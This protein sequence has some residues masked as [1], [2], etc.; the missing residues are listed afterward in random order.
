MLDRRLSCDIERK[1]GFS[2]RGACG[3]NYEVGFLEAGEHGVERGEARGDSAQ[4]AIMLVPDLPDNTEVTLH[5]AETD[6]DPK[7]ALLDDEETLLALYAACAE[8]DRELAS[9]GLDEWVR[10]LEREERRA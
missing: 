1:C 10:T 4:G 6:T 7:D 8:E 5:V 2:D 3:E 9:L